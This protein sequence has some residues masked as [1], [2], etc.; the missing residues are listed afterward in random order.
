MAVVGIPR[1]RG[2][3]RPA[4]R[5][6]GLSAVEAVR[7]DL[8]LLQLPVVLAEAEEGRLQEQRE[9]AGL[10]HLPRLRL[11]SHHTAREATDHAGQ[12]NATR[13]CDRG[14]RSRELTHHFLA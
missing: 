5:A 8:A 6:H 10:L 12:R 4:V 14:A 2:E 3:R 7:V 11:R 9:P 13:R 1:G